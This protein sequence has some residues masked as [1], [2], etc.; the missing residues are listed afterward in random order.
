MIF[1]LVECMQDKR[2]LPSSKGSGAVHT[3]LDAKNM[4]QDIKT[5]YMSHVFV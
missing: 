3:L 1:N 5:A 2:R 4:R